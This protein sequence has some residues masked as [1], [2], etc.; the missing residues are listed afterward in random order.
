MGAGRV[1][2]FFQ[3]PTACILLNILNQLNVH[4]IHTIVVLNGTGINKCVCEQVLAVSSETI[5]K[6]S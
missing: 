6:L 4:D 1:S 2:N 5:S 3:T